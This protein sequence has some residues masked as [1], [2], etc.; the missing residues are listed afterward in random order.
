M[1]YAMVRKVVKPARTSMRHVVLW[2]AKPKYRS[3][4]AS[5]GSRGKLQ[6]M[7]GKVRPG[8]TMSG[9]HPA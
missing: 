7:N 2:A 1:M 8:N 4:W 5:I 9:I 3:R 6:R